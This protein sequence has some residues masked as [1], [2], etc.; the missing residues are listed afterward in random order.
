[1]SISILLAED[2]QIVR[3]GTRQL[4][5]ELGKVKTTFKACLISM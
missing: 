1:M 3:E 4:L 2:H 5:E